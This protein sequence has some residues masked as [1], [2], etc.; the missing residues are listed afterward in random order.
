[1]TLTNI[2][3]CFTTLLF[4][5]QVFGF[6]TEN[7]N[8][9]ITENAI[10]G[11]E[12]CVYK[13]KSIVNSKSP[14]DQGKNIWNCFTVEPL[15]SC[16]NTSKTIEQVRDHTLDSI[17]RDLTRALSNPAMKQA[18]GDARSEADVDKQF[19]SCN[20]GLPNSERIFP[21]KEA[22]NK[23]KQLM[24]VALKY[25][26]PE[27]EEQNTKCIS[28][29]Q[30]ANENLYSCWQRNFEWLK[31]KLMTELTKDVQ[32][33]I[34]PSKRVKRAPKKNKKKKK[35]KISISTN[36]NSRRATKGTSTKKDPVCTL[37]QNS[38]GI[39]YHNF[40]VTVQS[41]LKNSERNLLKTIL[42]ENIMQR[43]RQLQD[44]TKDLGYNGKLRK[45]KFSGCNW[46]YSS[47]PNNPASFFYTL[48]ALGLYWMTYLNMNEC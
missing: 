31:L 28:N 8:S 11:L 40:E 32:W 45:M 29:L 20:L 23:M 34:L 19:D 2:L 33:T 10:I 5:Q 35:I 14:C 1:M 12:R 13:G 39:C 18:Q 42:G 9:T 21:N 43:L 6:H 7:C 15:Q 17:R 38:F 48:L 25:V 47:V 16:F 22:F 3:K 4:S 37:I 46:L 27:K 41:C 44:F 36:S 24:I 26:K 30:K